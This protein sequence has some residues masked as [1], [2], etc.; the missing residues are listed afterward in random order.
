MSL[1]VSGLGHLPRVLTDGLGGLF[2]QTAHS[3]VFNT[4]V[5]NPNML[6]HNSMG[7]E[8]DPN[9]ATWTPHPHSTYNARA[10][11][12]YMPQG[13]MLSPRS[14]D[15]LETLIRVLKPLTGSIRMRE[16]QGQTYFELHDEA[17][18]PTP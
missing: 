10:F 5:V 14:V 6:G 17:E 18:E 2:P 13:A 3:E 4:P 9:Y 7:T 8:G 1:L 12:I 16:V 11:I 15:R